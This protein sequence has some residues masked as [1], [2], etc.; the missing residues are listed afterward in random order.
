[1][2]KISDI[3]GAIERILN[4]EESSFKLNLNE[5][6]NLFSSYI[7]HCIYETKLKNKSNLQKEQIIQRN[8]NNTKQN[9]P[10]KKN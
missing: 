8:K 10:Y 7:R 9:T 4:E 2:T 6:K 1:M 5:D 3:R